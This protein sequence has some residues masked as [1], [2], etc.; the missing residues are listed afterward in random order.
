MEYFSSITLSIMEKMGFT[1]IVL[2]GLLI[3]SLSLILNLKTTNKYILEF[4]KHQNLDN[5]INLIFY[6]SFS[7]LLIFSISILSQYLNYGLIKNIF[8][9]LYLILLI[10]IIYSLFTI[11]FILKEIVRTSL[12]DS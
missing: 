2:I 12:K 5:F 4:K 10:F 8:S 3:A 1:P 9:I 6:T 7:L 11:T